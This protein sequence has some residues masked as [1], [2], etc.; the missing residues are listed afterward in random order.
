MLDIKKAIAIANQMPQDV[1]RLRFAVNL[2][3]AFIDS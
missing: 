3:I 1:N 2:T